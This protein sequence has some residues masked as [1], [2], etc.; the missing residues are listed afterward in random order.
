MTIKRRLEKLEVNRHDE[1]YEFES[2][3]LKRFCAELGI[4]PVIRR[5]HP[6]DALRDMQSAWRKEVDQTKT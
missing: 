6:D 1:F 4:E 3:Y 5:R 2:E